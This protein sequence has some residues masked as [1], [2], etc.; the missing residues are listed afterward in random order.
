MKK[1][2]TSICAAIAMVFAGCTTVPTASTIEGTSYAIGV[3]AGMV[4]NSVKMSDTTHDE[5][6][7][8]MGQIRS[9][10]PE[11]GVPLSTAWIEIANREIDKIVATGKINDAECRVIKDGMKIVINTADYIITKRWPEIV[12]Y[13][14]LMAA[15]QRGVC[16]GFLNVVKPSN[17]MMA[18][19]ATTVYDVEAYEYLMSVK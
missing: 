16:D 1:I 18:T 19:V 10:T 8:I 17:G 14:D 15:A 7:N 13:A 4:V 12:Q 2:I 3:S 9:Y 11:A 6:I 5:V